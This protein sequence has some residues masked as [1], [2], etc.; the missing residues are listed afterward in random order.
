MTHREREHE[1]SL[2]DLDRRAARCVYSIKAPTVSQRAMMI[3][4]YGD[5]PAPSE[6]LTE[7]PPVTEG[8]RA[9]LPRAVAR[10]RR[11]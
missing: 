10:E 7:E 5:N 11:R 9:E 4:A 2:D 6:P 1:V 8:P 3:L